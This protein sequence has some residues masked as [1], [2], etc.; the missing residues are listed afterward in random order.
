M[1]HSIEDELALLVGAERERPAAGPEAADRVWSGV[2]AR[3]EGA[4]P[5]ASVPSSGTPWGLLSVVG[6][7][8]L[9]VGLLGGGW[10]MASTPEPAHFE[11]AAAPALV[12]AEA[13]T[14]PSL[15][16]ELPVAAA[17][18]TDAAPEP[19]H[20]AKAGPRENAGTVADELAL[21]EKAR[22]ALDRGKATAALSV[23][24]THRRQFP[25]GA[26]REEAAALRASS[27]CKAG[28]TDAARKASASFLRRYPQS[29]HAARVRACAEG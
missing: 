7:V 4:P 23:L 8:V 3:L 27:L 28:R 11:V 9:A 20:V 1:T 17:P 6:A 12:L 25:K 19:K 10:A 5:P 22:T 24:A 29:V 13:P 15:R 21:I 18:S 14:I 2:Q 26:F 16:A